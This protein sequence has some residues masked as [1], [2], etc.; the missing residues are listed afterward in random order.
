MDFEKYPPDL[1]HDCIAAGSFKRCSV[2]FPPSSPPPLAPAMREKGCQAE[3][4]GHWANSHRWW[5]SRSVVKRAHEMGGVWD[6]EVLELTIGRP[7]HHTLQIASQ[8]AASNVV[9]CSSHPHPPRPLLP[10]CGRRGAKRRALGIGLTVTAGG[11]R[12][13]WLNVRM[14]WAVF[15]MSKFLS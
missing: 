12:G 6:V 9:Q 8:Q 13:Q 5:V 10:P 1:A 4:I 3:G 2:L 11:F 7:L 14:K 15:G